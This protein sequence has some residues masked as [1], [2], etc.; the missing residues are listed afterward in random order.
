M[1]DST[2]PGPRRVMLAA[3]VAIVIAMVTSWPPRPTN[4][5][6]WG[7]PLLFISS[8]LIWARARPGSRLSSELDAC[9]ALLLLVPAV[10]SRAQA[11]ASASFDIEHTIAPQQV[12]ALLLFAR[13][14]GQETAPL[15]TAAAAGYLV[16]GGRRVAAGAG[17]LLG[18][19]AAAAGGTAALEAARTALAGGDPIAAAELCRFVPWAGLLTIPGA[20]LGAL[21]HPASWSRFRIGIVSLTVLTAGWIATSPV[22]LM[23][24]A[25]PVPSSTE[26]LT[27]GAPGATTPATASPITPDALALHLATMG[28]YQADHATWPC[29]EAPRRWAMR[30]RNSAALPLPASASVGTLDALSQVLRTYTT[31]RLA[32]V[33][34]APDAPAG[35]L[36]RLVAWPVVPLLLDKPPQGAA[37]VAVTRGG[38][39]PLGDPPPLGTACALVPDDDVTVAHIWHAGRSLLQPDGPCDGIALMPARYRATIRA[40]PTMITALT[41]PARKV[42]ASPTRGL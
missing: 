31:H 12:D 5:F 35:P 21:L 18:A 37:V 23:A 15:L 32:L 20:L 27:V 7:L 38:P 29:E 30:T 3:G 33:G 1:D 26:R 14:A 6:V 16:L 25:L 11:D 19:A 22:G 34:H 8:G 17:A 39:V 4:A 24:R 41:C 40:D 2:A 36:E 10:A 13:R 42:K 9:L 28:R